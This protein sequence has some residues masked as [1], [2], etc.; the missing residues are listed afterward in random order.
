MK[1]AILYIALGRYDV[2]W[3]DFYKSCEKFFIPNAQKTY[4][5]FTDSDNIRATENMVKIPHENMGW[6][7]NTLMRFDLFLS[8]KDKLK[9]FDYIFFFNG[10][11]EFIAPV[12]HEVLP[13]EK[14]NDG[15]VMGLHPGFALKPRKEWTYERNPESMAYI[16]FDSGAYYVQGCLNGG[17]SKA[18]LKLCQECSKN[19]HTDLDKNIVAVWHDESHLNKYILDKNPLILG[20]NYLWPENFPGKKPDDIK[21]IQRDKSNP[22]YGGVKWL[23]GETDVRDIPYDIVI[24]CADK[25]FDDLEK[26]VKYLGKNASYRNIIVISNKC[27]ESLGDKVKYINESEIMKGLNFDAI[28]DYFIARNVKPARVGWYLQQFI[29]MAFAY[30]TDLNNYLTWDADTLML[31][32]IKFFD[33]KE[34]ILYDNSRVWEDEVFNKTVKAVLGYLRKTKETYIVEH[35][36]MDVQCMQDLIKTIAG[37][38]PVTDFW[39]IILDKISDDDLIYGGFSE[40]ETIGTFMNKKYHDKIAFRKLRSNRNAANIVGNKPNKYDIR[41]LTN[42]YDFVSFEKTHKIQ[43]GVLKIFKNKIKNLLKYITKR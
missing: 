36:M 35:M 10:N 41:A 1:I 27:P 13:D 29:K 15:L 19:T 22:V 28:R 38:C 25:D 40:F 42:N 8:I 30:K 34:R 16:P 43:I 6:P 39:K 37:N 21:I 12:G 9:D 11:M 7:N 24:C 33:D 20:C 23:R 17:T 32:P 26:T 14:L 5:V 3:D 18:Y 4:F 2:F 31:N